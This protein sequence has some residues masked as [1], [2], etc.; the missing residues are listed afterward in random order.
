MSSAK[1]QAASLEIHGQIGVIRLNRPDS[2]NAFNDA[3]YTDV[4]NALRELDGHPD[5]V[6]TVLTGTGRFFSSG[7]DV[8]GK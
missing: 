2:L 7:A 5:T 4:L 6:F 3:L 8:K 1:Y